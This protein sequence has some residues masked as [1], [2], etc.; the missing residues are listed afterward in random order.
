MARRIVC[1]DKSN[2]DHTRHIVSVGIGTDPEHANSKEDVPTV[3]RNI[4]NGVRYFTKSE[5]TGKV[6]DVEP[7]DC[8]CGVKTIRSK[9]DAVRDNNLDNLRACQWKS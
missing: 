8:S 7:F 1:V 9:A 5:S 6:A 3:R 4:Q 2:S